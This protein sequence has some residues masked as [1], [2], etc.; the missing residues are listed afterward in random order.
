VA[1]EILDDGLHVELDLRASQMRGAYLDQ[2]T[3]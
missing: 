2:P 1:W 3:E